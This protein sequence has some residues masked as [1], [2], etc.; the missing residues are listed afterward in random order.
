MEYAEKG[1]LRDLI[2]KRIDNNS[3]IDEKEFWKIFL[4]V[5]AGLRTLHKHKIVHLDVNASGVYLFKNGLVKLGKLNSAKVLRK[6]GNRSQCGTPVYASPEQWNGS[7]YDLRWT[8][9]TEEQI[10]GRLA[11]SCITWLL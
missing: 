7:T 5:A 6:D 8:L 10:Y 9:F 1:T 11:Q 4:Q 2:A 3:Y